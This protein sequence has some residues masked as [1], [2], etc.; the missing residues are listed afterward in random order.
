MIARFIDRFLEL[1]FWDA[2]VV[3][4]LGALALGS[5]WLA[6]SWGR[7]VVLPALV[8]CVLA[9]FAVMQ[10]KERLGR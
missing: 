5:F 3:F 2:L 7:P 8:G 10:A 9:G 4:G 6:L 1:R